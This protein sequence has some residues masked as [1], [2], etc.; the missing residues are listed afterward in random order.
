MSPCSMRRCRSSPP[1]SPTTRSAAT[2]RASSATG[3]RAGCRRPTCSRCKGGHILLAVNNEKQFVALAKAIGRPDLPK[4][5]TLRRLAGAACQRCRAARHHRGG[6]RR[7]RRQDL[8][9]AADRRP[10]CPAR[11]C[12]PSRRSSP[13]PSSPIAMCCSGLNPLRPTDLRRLGLPARARRRQDRAGRGPARRGCRRD[14]EEAGYGESEI[15]ALRRE[16]DLIHQGHVRLV[17]SVGRAAARSRR[18]RP[19]SAWTLNA[20]IRP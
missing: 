3:R 14:P 2:C 11:G 5:Q 8:G 10:T 9:G 18:S 1:T 19:S 20:G 12:G 15:A 13:I 16:G 7:R 4:D 6:A 17:G